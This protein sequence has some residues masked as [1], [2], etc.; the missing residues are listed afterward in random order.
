MGTHGEVNAP[1]LPFIHAPVS[2]STAAEDGVTDR[3]AA[4]SLQPGR[5][6]AEWN[7][8][9]SATRHSRSDAISP[10]VLVLRSKRKLSC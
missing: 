4:Q 5:C 10:P 3:L 7:T 2:R 1:T 9:C 6:A 8:R